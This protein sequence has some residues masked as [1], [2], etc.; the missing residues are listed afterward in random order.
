MKTVYIEESGMK[1]GPYSEHE[2]FRIEKS[3]IYEKI[4]E[5]IKMAEFLLLRSKKIWIVEAK[6]STPNPVTQPDFDDFI[7][8]V[9]EKLSN[10][11]SLGLAICLKRHPNEILPQAFQELNLANVDFRLVLVV[12]GHPKSWLPPLQD[13]LQKSL[14][15]ICKIWGLSAMAVIVM[16]DELAQEYKLITS[17]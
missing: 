5:N 17:E 13:A 7:K 10:A 1:F 15:T 12:N 8:E 16:N 9:H 6:Q 2:C 14:N 11:L 3:K 4:Q